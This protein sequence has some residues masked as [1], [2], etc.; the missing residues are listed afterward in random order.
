MYKLQ[1]WWSNHYERPLKDP[2]LQSYT[3]EELLYEYHDK[4][5]RRKAEEEHTEKEADR[6]EE[7]GIQ[8]NLDWAELEERKEL[9]ALKQKEAEEAQRAAEEQMELERQMEIAR[10]TMGSDFGDD[11]DTDFGDS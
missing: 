3:L 2:V 8:A 6:I 5:E 10:N 11:I 1:S 7:G 4:V 9:E